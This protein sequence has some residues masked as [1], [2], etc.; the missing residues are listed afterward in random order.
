MTPNDLDEYLQVLAR[1]QIGAASLKFSGGVEINVSFVPQFTA[2][3]N[4]TAP[5]P[6]GWKTLPH[7][8]DPADLRDNGEYKGD[9]PT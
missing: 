5:T 1:N 6:G 2:E 7:L 9:L 4:G 8:D 3:P